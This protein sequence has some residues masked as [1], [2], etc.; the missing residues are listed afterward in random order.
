MPVRAHEL[1]QKTHLE[2]SMCRVSAND[3]RVTYAPGRDAD[4]HD[5]EPNS[6]VF[7]AFRPAFAPD[8]I[9]S[10]TN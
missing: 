7:V 3:K 8:A 9:L 10:P 5:L 4:G 1:E 2:S 6:N